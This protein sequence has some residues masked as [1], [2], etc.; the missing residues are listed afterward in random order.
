MYS[1][2]QAGAPDESILVF[3]FLTPFEIYFSLRRAKDAGLN[4]VWVLGAYIPVIGI[5]PGAVLLLGKSV[6]TDTKI[7]QKETNG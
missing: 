5:I 7:L 3:A 6:S 4:W 1:L 2:V